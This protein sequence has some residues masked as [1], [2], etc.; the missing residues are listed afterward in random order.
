MSKD[1]DLKRKKSNAI[2]IYSMCRLYQERI[3][4]GRKLTEEELSE[5]SDKIKK[6]LAA[7][8]NTLFIE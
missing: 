7:F 6:E 2:E 3:S 5:V 8:E 1:E 4:K